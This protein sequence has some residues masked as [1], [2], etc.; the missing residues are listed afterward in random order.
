MDVLRNNEGIYYPYFDKFR[1]L[2]KPE[3]EA[4]V[5]TGTMKKKSRFCGRNFLKPPCIEP[6][7]PPTPDKESIS[8]FGNSRQIVPFTPNSMITSTPEKNGNELRSPSSS[9]YYIKLKYNESDPN[10]YNIPNSQRS[11]GTFKLDS[12]STSTSKYEGNGLWTP[13]KHIESKDTESSQNI[14]NTPKRYVPKRR[15][16]LNFDKPAFDLEE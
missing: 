7:T 13:T 8:Y 3:E 16:R 14:Y 4:I 11:F 1:P 2:L 10:V 15:R 9:P 12:I 5:N 6:I